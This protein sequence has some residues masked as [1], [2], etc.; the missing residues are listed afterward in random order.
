MLTL[1]LI[2]S[3][4]KEAK[5]QKDEADQYQQKKNDIENIKTDYVLWQIWRIEESKKLHISALRDLNNEISE[6]KENEAEIENQLQSCKKELAVINKS[7]TSLGYII[8]LICLTIFAFCVYKDIEFYV[9]LFL[10]KDLTNK[11]KQLNNIRPDLTSVN[12]KLKSMKKRINDLES[13]QKNL[14]NDR[15]DQLG[16]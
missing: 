1:L 7:L 14:Q 15:D 12:D 3:Q 4:C 6:S 11:T 16:T 5:L 13:M 2:F 8:L 9:Y 10:D